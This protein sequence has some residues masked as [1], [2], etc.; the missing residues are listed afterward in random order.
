M[1]R[2]SLT[3]IKKSAESETNIPNIAL[4]YH[5]C[6][7][8]LLGCPEQWNYLDTFILDLRV[9]FHGINY[10]QSE[11]HKETYVLI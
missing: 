6:Y 8:G 2:S 10:P 9:S 11:R 5:P 1:L 4:G 3:K 7:Q